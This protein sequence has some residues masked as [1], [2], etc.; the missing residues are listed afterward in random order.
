[1]RDRELSPKS[2]IELANLLLKLGF[3]K[4]A[5][6]TL[7]IAARMYEDLN[8]KEEAINTYN[9]ILELDPE[10][11]IA[12]KRLLFIKPKDKE[13]IL[14]IEKFLR[15]MMGEKQ[16]TKPQELKVE[17]KKE[18]VRETDYKELFKY[19]QH[20]PENQ[21][22]RESFINTLLI[23][24]AV[25]EALEEA[26]IN[27]LS[28]PSLKN[29]SLLKEAIE[30]AGMDFVPYLEQLSS[31][32]FSEKAKEII[33]EELAKFYGEKEKT[34]NTQKFKKVDKKNSIQFI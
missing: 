9:R 21:G 3:K 34:E 32:S 33:Q 7:L 18:S 1:M 31:N 22:S 2:K 12:K 30:K 11:E 10:N 29:L 27:F 15:S 20:Y 24:G 17:E 23:F 14:E 26:K 28:N 16:V 19:V 25:K 5:I 6:E 4:N 8:D 13:V